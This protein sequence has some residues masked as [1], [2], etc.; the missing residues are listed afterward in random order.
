MKRGE[1]RPLLRLPFYTYTTRILT[2]TRINPLGDKR[3]VDV[4]S[5]LLLEDELALLVLFGS[6]IGTVILPSERGLALDATDI[7]HRMQASGHVAI[8][9]ISQIDVGDQIEKISSSMLTVERTT[10]QILDCGQ[11]SLAFLAAEHTLA[12]KV[13]FVCHAHLTR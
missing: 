1:K 12:T 2:K 8:L 6:H 10:H 4:D 5:E 11:V 9:G 13:L 7:S 3:L